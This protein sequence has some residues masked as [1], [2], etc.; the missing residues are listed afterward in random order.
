LEEARRAS[1]IFAAGTLELREK[2]DFLLHA[3]RGEIGI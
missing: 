3:D 1:V 2:P